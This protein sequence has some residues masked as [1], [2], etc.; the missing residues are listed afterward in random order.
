M[1]HQKI[2]CLDIEGGY[3]GSSRSLFQSLSNFPEGAGAPEVW[4]RR[5]GPVQALYA[6][7]GIPCSVTPTMPHVSALPR[8]SRN[9][10]VFSRARLRFSASRAFRDALSAAVNERFDIVHFNH[11][12]LFLL[13]RWLRRYTQ[14]PFSM[15]FRTNLVPS[16]TAR[17]QARVASNA[18]DHAVFISENEQRSWLALGLEPAQ[19]SVIYN[20]AGTAKSD[21]APHLDIP[22]DARLK[23][24][25]LSNYAW[26]RGVDRL[27]EVA[28]ALA[29]RGRRDVLFVVAGNMHFS[30]SLP[31]ERGAIS[32]HGGSLADYAM[33]KGVADM[34]VFLGHVSEPERVL[35]GC[36]AL[37]RLSREDNPWG[38]DV[39]EALGAGRPVIAT[40]SY[41]R[42]VE[43][44]V[45]GMLAP[46]YSPDD[47]AAKIIELADDRALISRLG[48]AAQ[49]RIETLCNGAS[50][51]ADLAA[52]WQGVARQ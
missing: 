27:V 33:A 15:H 38:R 39:I 29:A 23:I 36:H 11:E 44:G 30:G 49:A 34:F 24:A 40:G 22:D 1:K 46:S 14:A 35:A 52:V 26:I 25:S 7:A 50:R 4:C 21:A 13:A 17:W 6:N 19:S 31:G 32:R 42:F 2:L 45:T 47:I 18:I 28:A 10:Y 41:D 51:A 3:G 48:V 9:L 43:S 37:A 20:I 5:A 8:L 12:A 16:I